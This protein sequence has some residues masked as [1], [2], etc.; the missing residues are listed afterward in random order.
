M[1][2]KRLIVIPDDYDYITQPDCRARLFVPDSKLWRGVFVGALKGLTDPY[3]WD[4][5][6]GDVN[7]AVEVAHILLDNITYSLCQN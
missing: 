7:Q 4:H 3:V 5:T 6:T 1:S 2:N